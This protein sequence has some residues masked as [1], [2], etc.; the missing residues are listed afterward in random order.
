MRNILFGRNGTKIL[1]KKKLETIKLKSLTNNTLN[2]STNKSEGNN[3]SFINSSLLNIDAYSPR[4]FAFNS[5]KS[6]RNKYNE[7]LFKNANRIL[8]QRANNLSPL[9]LSPFALKR[10]IIKKSKEI[11]LSNYMIKLI[12]KKRSDINNDL[13][14]IRTSLKNCSDNIE[15]DYELFISSIDK[16]NK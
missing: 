4:H 12:K 3:F 6:S 10:V 1:L 5:P 15:K 14:S 11:S 9:S 13:I 7:E 8:V 16:L 2:K